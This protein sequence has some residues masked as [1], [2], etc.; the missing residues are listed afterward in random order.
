M[1]APRT[2][3]KDKMR[4]LLLAILA[5]TLVPAAAHAQRTQRPALHG[6]EWMAVTGKPLGTTAGA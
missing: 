1:R 3:T 4:R 6:Q 5:C 2:T